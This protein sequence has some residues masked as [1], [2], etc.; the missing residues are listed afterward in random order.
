[1]TAS[2]SHWWCRLDST[3]PLPFSSSVVTK[4]ILFLS[5][6]NVTKI[7]HCHLSIEIGSST[8][9]TA[10]EWWKQALNLGPKWQFSAF[11]FFIAP[12]ETNCMK[13]CM[14]YNLRA[15]KVCVC[16]Q[17][18]SEGTFHTE[19]LPMHAPIG[20]AW[21][22]LSVH[23]WGCRGTSVHAKLEKALGKD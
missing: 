20:I 1:M 2:A 7:C 13:G 17:R 8:G 5:D 15:L 14:G 4:K 11:Y 21:V 9:R 3:I 6:Q 19:Q 12:D 16:E 10:T 23:L 18:G 22:G